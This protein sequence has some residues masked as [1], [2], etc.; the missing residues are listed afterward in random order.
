MITQALA[1]E[2]AGRATRLTDNQLEELEL[3]VPFAEPS[4]AF[5]ALAPFLDRPDPRLGPL[6]AQTL[7]RSSALPDELIDRLYNALI[8][9]VDARAYKP[10]VEML[11]SLNSR[12]ALCGVKLLGACGDPRSAR[13]LESFYHKAG[14]ANLR[15]EVLATLYG[16]PRRVSAEFVLN[17]IAAAKDRDI[18]DEAMI[19][20]A[21]IGAILDVPAL[22][23][24]NSRIRSEVENIRNGLAYTR[25]THP[26]RIP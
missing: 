14:G 24:I 7:A 9:I 19:L 17:I 5:D 23:R 2:P 10:A 6:I 16:M 22:L 26:E 8:K 1:P 15:K 20:A 4:K 25:R 3:E 11:D 13:A 12:L 18:R 21:R